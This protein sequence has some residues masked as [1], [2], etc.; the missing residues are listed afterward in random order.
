VSRAVVLALAL[1]AAGCA[2]Y[3]GAARDFSPRRLSTEPGWLALRGVPFE[4]QLEE[5]DCG[6]AAIAM[7]IAYW[8]GRQPRAIAAALRPAPEKG[9]AAGRMRDL[10]RRGGLAAFIVRGELADLERELAAGRPVL[11]GLVKPHGPKRVL[12]HYEVVVG[13][14]KARK[15]VVTLDPASGWRENGLD[16]F[17]EEWAP[18]KRLALV[19]SAR[20]LHGPT[21]SP[22]QSKTAKRTPR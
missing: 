7:V 3:T 12:T 13:L 16:A 2:S 1:L 22:S 10:A 5:A 18:S 6:A 17:L 15:L 9:I 14:H 21:G 8:T 11:V 4:R 20:D 19:V